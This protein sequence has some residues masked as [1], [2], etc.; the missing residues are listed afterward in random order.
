[1]SGGLSRFQRPASLR[2]QF[3]LFAVFYGLASLAIL[4]RYDF[5]PSVL[6]RFGHDYVAQNPE[7]TPAG[8]VRLTGNEAHGGNGYDGQ[9]FYYYA[10]TLLIP[11]EWPRGFSHAY[12]APRAGYPALVAPFAFFG[13]QGT[14]IGMFLVQI[15]FF[16]F[17]IYRLHKML[18]DGQKHLATVYILSPFALLSFVLMVSDAVMVSLVLIGY[19]YYREW[20]RHQSI[21]LRKLAATY[22]CFALAILTKEPAL[23]FLFPLGLHALLRRRW[24]QAVFLIAILVPA[25]AWQVYLREVHGMVPA[26]ILTIF[27]APFAGIFAMLGETLTLSLAFLRA[28]GGGTLVALIKQSAYVLL[29]IVLIAAAFAAFTGDRRRVLPFRLAILL[30]ITSVIFADYYYFWSVFDNTARML[31]LVVPLVILL[32]AETPVGERRP[33]VLPFFAGMLLLSA[34]VFLRI[35]LLTPTFPYDVYVPYDGPV[36]GNHAPVLTE[37]L[38]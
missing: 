33:F 14:L 21:S 38:R 10:R 1:M 35:V 17:S 12:R 13:N 18:A 31:T 34:F 11:G 36:Y 8:A 27:L 5:N 6:I 24:I 16:V 3:V 25:A 9:I 26:G 19:S 22:A 37:T 20:D 29:L 2:A 23:F 32:Y 30:T 4:A 15:G 28:P 7:Y